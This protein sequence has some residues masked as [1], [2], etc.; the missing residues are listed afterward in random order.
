MVLRDIIHYFTATAKPYIMWL[1][2]FGILEY[3]YL[4]LHCE[5]GG[6][7]PDTK[8][9]HKKFG[10]G[11]IMDY[12]YYNKRDKGYVNSVFFDSVFE[13]YKQWKREGVSLDL[14]GLLTPI[15]CSELEI[16]R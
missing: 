3:P 14:G 15:P 12:A 10:A 13:E 8:V 5:Y 11:E 1:Y 2:K 4:D 7:K 6:L 16:V 9:F